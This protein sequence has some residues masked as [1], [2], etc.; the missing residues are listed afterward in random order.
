MSDSSSSERSDEE[1]HHYSDT[2]YAVIMWCRDWMKRNP[3][4]TKENFTTSLAAFKSEV[5][6][7]MFARWTLRRDKHIYERV[8]REE[9]DISD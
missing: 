1:I 9:A 5:R 3:P 2:Y 8:L 4:V 6:D 7:D